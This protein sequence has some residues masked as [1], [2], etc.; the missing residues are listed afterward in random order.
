MEGRRLLLL[1]FLVGLLVDRGCLAAVKDQQPHAAAAERDQ[2]PEGSSWIPYG[3]DIAGMGHRYEAVLP[4]ARPRRRHF[5]DEPELLYAVYESRPVLAKEGLTDEEAAWVP[6]AAP[7]RTIKE[8]YASGSRDFDHHFGMSPRTPITY[9]APHTTPPLLYTEAPTHD[10]TP[11]TDAT[12]PYTEAPTPYT[13]A[14]TPY[15]EAPTPH[16]T[17]PKPHTPPQA[18]PLPQQPEYALPLQRRPRKYYL[19]GAGQNTHKA[20]PRPSH[21]GFRKYYIDPAT[22]GALEGPPYPTLFPA[23]PPPT[24]PHP[25][26][27]PTIRQYFLQ[28]PGDKEP[29]VTN[30]TPFEVYDKLR[31]TRMVDTGTHGRTVPGAPTSWVS[32]SSSSGAP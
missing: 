26:P 4:L 27:P 18:P 16:T 17:A 28:K 10:P 3:W 5:S 23:H 22:K 15:T 13:K 32:F 14:P 20:P 29:P 2:T 19:T 12:T 30:L 1:P 7:L 24:Y 6:D 31:K 11:Y 8:H 9:T 21:F 25:R